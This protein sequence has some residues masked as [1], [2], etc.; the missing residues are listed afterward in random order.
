MPIQVAYAARLAAAVAALIVTGPA[1]A[2]PVGERVTVGNVRIDRTEVTVGQFRAF[3]VATGL[4]TAAEREGGGFEY[5]AG[6][7]RRA[8]WTVYA[9]FGV[10][11]SVSG[12]SDLEPAVHVTWDEARAYC[13]HAGGR[14]PTVAEWELAAY[15]EQRATPPAPYQTGK[16]YEFPV[17]DPADANTSGSDSWP[18]SAP[19]GS[20]KAGV[21]GLYDMGANVWE[22]VDDAAGSE[23]RTMGGSWW[24]GPDQ[25]RRGGTASKPPAFY[26]VYVGFRCVY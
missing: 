17:A 21:N 5:V 16:T 12:A 7:Q 9:P 1:G 14:L 3:A 13:R 2:A 11:L 25:M 19:A 10:P 8:G 18:R 23:R 26:A 15:T 4:K 20:T 24:Y 6:W 22:W